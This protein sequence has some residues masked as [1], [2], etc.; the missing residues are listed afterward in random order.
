M[1]LHADAAALATPSVRW[2]WVMSS[3]NCAKDAAISALTPTA[4]ATICTKHPAVMPSPATMP[5][6]VPDR[7]ALVTMYNTSGPGVNGRATSA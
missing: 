6:R 4:A 1:R 2:T 3:G 7:S 5:A